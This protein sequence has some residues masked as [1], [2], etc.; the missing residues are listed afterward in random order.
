M[1]HQIDL[2]VIKSS[3]NAVLDHLIED[4]Q[5]PTIEIDPKEELYWHIPPGELSEV[6]NPRT[7]WI[8][9]LLRTILIL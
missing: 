4:L 1:S 8:S 3:I 5:Q 2:R 6:S 7:T 9:V